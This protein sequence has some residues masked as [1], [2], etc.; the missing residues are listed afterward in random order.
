MNPTTVI[1]RRVVLRFPKSLL[2]KPVVYRLIKDYDLVFNILRADVTPREQGFVVLEL[3]GEEGNY[4]RAM[5]YLAELKVEVKLLEQDITRDEDKCTHCGACT[6][7]CPTDALALER[8]SMQVLF[9]PALCVAC[10]QCIPAC[11][12]GAM[13]VHLDTD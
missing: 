9:D 13:E 1:R 2:D 5:D 8:D 7:V 12:T 4:R 6:A 3:S 11:P 10:E